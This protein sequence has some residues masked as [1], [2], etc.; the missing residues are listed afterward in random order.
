MAALLDL[1]ALEPDGA[2]RYRLDIVDNYWIIGGPNG[3]YLAAILA[4]AGDVE[5]AEPERHLRSLTTHYLRPPTVGPAEVTVTVEQRGRSV[6]W[7]RMQLHQAGRPILLATGA[8]A[9]PRSGLEAPRLA[10]PD[11]PPPDA[12]HPVETVRDQPLRLHDQWEIRTPLAEYHRLSDGVPDVLW[13]IRPRIHGALDG[14]TVVA[15]S[16]A[17]PPPI[18]VTTDE[19]LGVPTV[20][21]TVH[22]RADLGSVP[23]EPGDWVLG[24]FVTRHAHGGFLDED[25]AMWL[26]DGTL[27]ALS[28]QLAVS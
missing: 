1:I 17:L 12:C 24:R 3:G 19:P 10:P 16:D 25:G 23:W 26:Q 5:L 7:L 13:W 15:I 18:F 6:A 14:P 27:V 2:G 20:D 4:H 22:V 21:L 11:C 28:R 9:M 8:W